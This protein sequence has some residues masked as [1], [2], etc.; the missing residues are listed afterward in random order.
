MEANREIIIGLISDTHGYLETN[1]LKKLQGSELIIHAGDIG[2][3]DII[4]NLESVAPVHAVRGNMD[5]GSWSRKL[6]NTVIVKVKNINIYVL[7][8]LAKL[9]LDP[10]ASGFQA[11]ISGHLHR[12]VHEEHNGVLFINP[13][14]ATQPRN[15]YSA[16]IAQLK[17]QARK[18]SVKFIDIDH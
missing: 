6:P 3:P 4:Q 8:D 16:T 18:L 15:N 2:D 10:A 13:G 17:I 11:V 1:A 14:S 5:N 9:D 7:H 12:P